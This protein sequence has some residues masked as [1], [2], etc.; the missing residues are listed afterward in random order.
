MSVRAAEPEPEPALALALAPP[1]LAPTSMP[2]SRLHFVLSA[3]LNE[4]LRYE[5]ASTAACELKETWYKNIPG[6]PGII[7]GLPGAIGNVTIQSY[8]PPDDNSYKITSL[9]EN[10]PKV[11]CGE[12]KCNHDFKVTE[13]TCTKE[14]NT[15]KYK[16]EV[17]NLKTKTNSK[18]VVTVDLTKGC[19][20][21]KAYTFDKDN[22][23]EQLQKVL[24]GIAMF[25]TK[26]SAVSK[27]TKI[28]RF[29]DAK[30]KKVMAKKGTEKK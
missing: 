15:A 26:E 20:E 25:I 16:F 19:G 2:A 8:K 4:R 3:G 21:K 27:L 30:A 18:P 7:T 29:V 1:R 10:I 23:T 9:F 12:D 5:E 6:Q 24:R 11:F 17:H 28:G 13:V 22:Y 14:A